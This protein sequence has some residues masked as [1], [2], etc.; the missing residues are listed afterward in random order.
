MLPQPQGL[1][2][3]QYAKELPD[4]ES[5]ALHLEQKHVIQAR[6]TAD[7]SEYQA[8]VLQHK[9]LHV[10]RLQHK[11]VTDVD[12]LRWS[13]L[14]VSRNPQRHRGTSTQLKK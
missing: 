11:I 7:S 14:V 10:H 9:C 3:Q 2:F 13:S 12:W 1:I 5:A 4:S 8:A 6:W